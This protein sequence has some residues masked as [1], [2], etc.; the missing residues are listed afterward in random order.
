MKKILFTL[1]FVFLSCKNHI[2]SI[3]SNHYKLQKNEN[4]CNV[5]TQADIVYII[6][7]EFDLKGN[8]LRIPDNCTLYFTNNGKIKNGKIYFKNTRLENAVSFTNIKFSGSLLNKEIHTDWFGFIKDEKIEKTTM[9][10]A[11]L[12]KQITLLNCKNIIIDDFYPVGET[13]YLTSSTTFI[14]KDWSPSEYCQTYEYTYNPTNGFYTVNPTSLFLL[15]N[16]C[17]ISLYGVKLTGF[18]E[19]F[20]QNAFSDT[21][22]FCIHAE[23][24]SSDS[25]ISGTIRAVYNSI[26]QGFTYGIEAIGTYIEKIQNTTFD[27]CRFGIYVVWTSDFDV[28]GCRFTN[29][30]GSVNFSV[31]D[32]IKKSDIDSIKLTSSA[33]YSSS[34]GMLNINK[35]Y[36]ENNFIGYSIIDEEVILNIQ[37]CIFKDN[38]LTNIFSLSDINYVPTCTNDILGSHA[39]NCVAISENTFIRTKANILNTQIFIREADEKGTNMVF[40]KNQFIDT[41]NSNSDNDCIFLISAASQQNNRGI[42]T[43]NNNDY[44]KSK[45]K[46]FYQLLPT[47]TNSYQKEQTGLF[48]FV[49]SNNIY[50]GL[51]NY[52][53]DFIMINSD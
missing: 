6:D 2:D 35:C 23:Y 11:N 53:S 32:K 44:S 34:A 19:E 51:F 52:T 49:I 42:V 47:Y 22:T 26:I 30:C 41:F 9:Y 28:F 50:N 5:I 40:S 12:L 45:S 36:F 16:K 48:K 20:N 8:T 24:S 33:I 37:N 13:I 15:R 27:S 21:D 38:K 14:G 39:I 1:L 17:E 4:I 7:S 10:N 31:P 18:I 29:C 3:N 46:N 43:C 25:K